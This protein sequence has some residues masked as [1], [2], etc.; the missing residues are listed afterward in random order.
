MRAEERRTFP[1]RVRRSE[2]DS[3]DTGIR[4]RQS[5]EPWAG[6]AGSP[7]H[8]GLKVGGGLADEQDGESHIQ[9]PR[10]VVRGYNQTKVVARLRVGGG[11][12][13][14]LAQLS[15]LSS[16]AWLPVCIYNSGVHMGQSSDSGWGV[17]GITPRVCP[18]HFL[19]LKT[20]LILL[21][22]CA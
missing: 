16:P 9:E 2:L 12:M 22:C 11:G 4:T 6:G 7:Q 15:F 1:E 5:A 8:P 19:D 18:L 17:Q 10:A 13:N 3:K 20:I 21:L 14:V